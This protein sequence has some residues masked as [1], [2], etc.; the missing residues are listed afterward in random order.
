[1]SA[2][3]WREDPAVLEN[4]VRRYRERPESAAPS[5]AEAERGRERA[6]H[7]RALLAAVG[8]V[9][10]P[11]AQ[12][13]LALVRRR[14][15]LRGMAKRS[16]LQSLDVARAAARVI[17]ADLAARGL[18]EHADDVFQL[19]VPEA[20]DGGPQVGD[21][22]RERHRQRAEHARARVPEQW[23]GDVDAGAALSQPPAPEPADGDVVRGVGVSAGVVEG[24]VRVVTDPT[25]TDVEPDE[26][27][28][29]P[30]TDP[31]WSSIMF[32]SSALVV[33]IGGALSH[34][35]VVA[36][37]LGIPCVV[38]TRDGSRTLR[39]GDRVRVD[40][41]TGVVEILARSGVPA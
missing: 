39:T 15:P 7:E 40:G 6:A 5:A 21:I 28:V 11:G 26:V 20:A 23:R 12:A 3:V 14:I 16:M 36:R 8:P 17:G 4:L 38:N 10:R 29:A 2:R 34:A 33:D 13:V 31:S 18:L 30:T 27:L 1:V 35:A 22:A 41:G 25:F 24:T 9:R 32:V 19:T 37:E